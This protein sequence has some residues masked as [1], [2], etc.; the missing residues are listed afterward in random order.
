MFG[1]N[2]YSVIKFHDDVGII[3]AIKGTKFV[4][5]FEAPNNEV[6]ICTYPLS[7]INKYKV[8]G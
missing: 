1:Y 4:V 2:V 6:Q 3:C 7:M 5:M 8:I